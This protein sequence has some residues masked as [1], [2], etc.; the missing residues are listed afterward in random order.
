[1]GIR[2]DNTSE[3]IGD[4]SCE[5]YWTCERQVKSLPVRALSPIS[6]REQRDSR[7]SSVGILPSQQRYTVT[8]RLETSNIVTFSNKT[9]NGNYRSGDS[10]PRVSSCIDTAAQSRWGCILLNRD[11]FVQQKCLEIEDV[12]RFA[13]LRTREP[14]VAQ[15]NTAAFHPVANFTGNRTYGGHHRNCIEKDMK[16][17]KGE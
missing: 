15:G 4:K 10:C 1:M 16:K 11:V 3:E 8:G 2:P 5:I 17:K 13:W 6:I 12:I 9:G 14:V 7:P